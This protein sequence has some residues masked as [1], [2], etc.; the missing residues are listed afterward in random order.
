MVHFDEQGERYLDFSIYHLQPE[1]GTRQ[2]VPIL[3]FNSL[4]GAVQ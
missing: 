2:F 1:R 3:H 4:T